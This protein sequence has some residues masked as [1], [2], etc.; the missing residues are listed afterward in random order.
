MYH[1]RMIFRT[2]AATYIMICTI[3]YKS[4]FS[5]GVSQTLRASYTSNIAAFFIRKIAQ[6]VIHLPPLIYALKFT[7]VKILAVSA[8]TYGH[9]HRITILIIPCGDTNVIPKLLADLGG[10]GRV[11]YEAVPTDG[12][13]CTIEL[14]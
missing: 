10:T 14:N 8:L 6:T 2:K 5:T 3:S 12:V 13:P 1:G 9:G 4:T 7:L 11:L